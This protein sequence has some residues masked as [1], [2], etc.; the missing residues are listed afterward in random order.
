MNG[1]QQPI[2][3]SAATPIARRNAK[4]EGD[5]PPQYSMA[6]VT[7]LGPGVLSL[8]SLTVKSVYLLVSEIPYPLQR[9]ASRVQGQ[10][11]SVKRQVS[12]FK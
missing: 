5:T 6:M 11:A 10:A 4:R 8:N 3:E 9:Q 2:S 12:S 7:S 1:S